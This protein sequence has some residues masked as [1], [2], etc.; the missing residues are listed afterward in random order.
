MISNSAITAL[1]FLISCLLAGTKADSPLATTLNGTYQGK[2]LPGWDQD[3]FLGVPFAQPPV[4]DLR[5][6]WPQSLDSAFDGIK[7]ATQY[8][9]SCMQY[10]DN[11]T[12]S[13][14]CLTL[15]VIRPSSDASSTPPSSPLPVL[16]WI[17][18]GGLGV[19]A[20]VDPQYNLSGIVRLSQEINQPILAVSINYRVNHWGFLQTPELLVEGGASNAGLL[21]Q[22]MALRWIQ[23]NIA[24]FGGDSARVTVWGE[25]AGAQSIAYQMFAYGGRD[26]GLFSA[27]ILESGGP[28]GCPVK[29]LSYWEV[30]FENLTRSAGCWEAD[31]RLACMRSVSQED[32]YAARQT[33]EWQGPLIDGDFLTGY[34]S[35]LMPRGEFVS[36][37]LLT[38][39]N[40]HEGISFSPAT[41]PPN[42]PL[43]KVVTEQELMT[44][45]LG[46]RM[47]DISPLT[48]KRLLDLYPLEA[49]CDNDAPQTS[50]ANCSLFASKDAQWQRAVA[51]GGDMVMIAGRR[52]MCELFSQPSVNQPVYSYRFDARPWGSSESQGSRHFDNVAFSFQNISGLLGPSPEN[53]SHMQLARQI[54]KAYI[55]FVH[56]HDPNPSGSRTGERRSYD[57]ENLPYWP[58]YSSCNPTN[59]VLD[60][61]GSY[62]EPDTYRKEGMAFINSPEVSRELLG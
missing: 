31:D 2:Y 29:D 18:G 14:D 10:A 48:V 26:D 32:L 45:F 47:Y 42:K 41:Y 15:N 49:M 30:P 1:A 51:I 6:R 54:G 40:T 33:Q 9:Y 39:D 57:E 5:Y 58:R 12:M 23:E 19:G 34:P 36:V 52:R 4:G 16:V 3:V 46:W 53:D 37:P 17:Y 35:Q 7:N 27:A 28:T 62:I 43:P 13:E 25:S 44:S 55:N 20:S 11:L 22:R 38:G 8:G 59:M 21:D 50:A 60:S 24:G 56:Y 61:F